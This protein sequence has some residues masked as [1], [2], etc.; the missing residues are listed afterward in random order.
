MNNIWNR[1]MECMNPRERK[2]LQLERLKWSVKYVYNRVKPYREKME[3]AGVKPEDINSLADLK[4][5]PFMTKQDLRDNY[6][7][8]LFATDME[9]VVRI[10]GSSG[11]TG[12]LTLVGYTESDIELWSEMMA[13]TATAG[14]VTRKS[15]VQISYGYGLFTG[16]MGMH[17]GSEKIGATIIPMSG[18]NSERQIMIM[19]DLGVEVLACTP[20]Y[21]LHLAET[22]RKMGVDLSELKLKYGVFGA[23]P[24]SEA[25][26][27]EIE[28]AL[29]IR[30]TDIYGLCEIIGPGVAFECEHQCGM[31]IN[32]D[33]FYPEIISPDTG[34]VLEDGEQGEIV[35]TTLTKEAFPLIRYRTRDLTRLIA[36]TCECG[37]TTRRME[38]VL[39]RSDDMIIIRGVNVFP[40]Q[41]ETILMEMGEVDPHYL[42]VVD[43]VNN[44]DTLEV[45]IEVSDKI[46][47][48]SVRF[49]EDL[50]NRIRDRIHTVLGIS[51]KVTLVEPGTIPRSEGKAK[52]IV[53]KRKI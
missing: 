12:K 34:E 42:L 14:G 18:G 38:K 46:F 2:A 17:H 45:Q 36:D 7:F 43:R 22:I 13:R 44:M 15:I 19:K 50:L 23:E 35:F 52:R 53:D 5:M 21:A 29:G 11:T 3:A 16:G 40:T 27:K 31:H 26:R 32:E 28:R 24:C 39:G 49:V 9:D 6:P 8:G 41:I 20:S 33:C 4:Y 51:V 47:S 48:D 25:M 10:Q 37:R 1:E 30:A